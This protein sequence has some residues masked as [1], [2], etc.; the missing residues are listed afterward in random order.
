MTGKQPQTWRRLDNVAKIFP[1]TSSGTDTRVFRFSCYLLEDID[2]Q[3]LQQALDAIMKHFQ[4]FSVV[5]RKGLFWYYLEQRTLPI[6]AVPET[7]APCAAIDIDSKRTPL[8]RVS[9]YRDRINFDVY[10]SLTD[11]TGAVQFLTALVCQYLLL[12]H[13][14]ELQGVSMPSNLI[15]AMDEQAKDSFQKYYQK[16]K[17]KY[18]QNNLSAYHF[19]SSKRPEADLNMME[20]VMSAKQVLAAAHRYGTTITGYLTALFMRAYYKTMYLRER[21]HPVVISLPVNLRKHFPS[22]T[23][24]NFFGMVDLSY[25][26]SKDPKDLASVAKKVDTDLRKLLQKDALMTLMNHFAAMEHN[27]AIR[28]APLP[29]KNLVLRFSRY[30]AGRHTTSVI[31]NVGRIVVPE[32]FDRYIARYSFL[33]AT[34][35]EQICICS[36]G[37]QLTVGFSSAQ[38]DTSLQRYFFE[39][40]SKDG[41]EVTIHGSDL[42]VT[43]DEEPS[44]KSRKAKRRVAK[45][46]GE[47]VTDAIL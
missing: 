15:S 35:T 45:K 30:L 46:Q 4:S 36:F 6:R 5:L 27:M 38:A 12:K 43:A 10:H 44:E 14:E 42:E 47:G 28:M 20:G 9:Y 25:D 18:Q 21:K 16:N 7:V 13:S 29:L 33:V 8:F 17:T 41:V 39:G 23:N 19:K 32:P 40:L 24:G 2:P 1:S 22:T 26:F 34:L 11:G 37:D 3:I 31:S